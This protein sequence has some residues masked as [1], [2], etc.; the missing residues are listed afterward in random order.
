MTPRK[1]HSFPDKSNLQIASAVS[2]EMTAIAR[3]LRRYPDY[4][5]AKGGIT[6]HDIA[7]RGLGISKAVVLGQVLPGVPVIRAE[8][9]GRPIIY[10]IFPG[11]VGTD[12]ALVRIK[13][14]YESGC[15]DANNQK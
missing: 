12:T 11:N 7:V 5:V 13:E 1:Y 9:R 2:N 3:M 14:K 8:K 15:Q 6:S 10:T 4:I